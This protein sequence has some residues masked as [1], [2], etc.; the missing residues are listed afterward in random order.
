MNWN[1]KR[2]QREPLDVLYPYYAGFAADFA[3]Q[4]I[5]GAQ[6]ATGARLLDP[7]NG[8]GTTTLAATRLGRSATG[9]DLNPVAALVASAKLAN[10][11]DALHLHGLATDICR[12][13]ARSQA[14]PPPGLTVWLLPDVAAHFSTIQSLVMELLSTP[15]DDA[16]H[17]GNRAPPPIAAFLTA[18]LLRS[19][20]SLAR[21]RTSTNPVWI[22][23]G[24][25]TQYGTGDLNYR[26]LNNITSFSKELGIAARDTPPAELLIGDS[27]S[28]PCED[29][30]F[31]FAITSPPYC[32]RLDYVANT[33]FELAA[34]GLSNGDEQLGELRKAS[35]GTPLTRERRL[36]PIK[37][38]WPRPV[39]QLLQ[40]VQCHPSADSAS[41]YYKNH[42]QYFDDAYESLTEL[43][44][45]LKPGGAAVLVLQT[46][47]YKDVLIDLPELYRA[48][49]RSLGFRSARLASLPVVRVMSQIN[50]RARRHLN[51]RT[52]EEVVIAL[53]TA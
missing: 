13:A 21:V 48:M 30:S 36:Q 49:G 51:D 25:S 32:T 44:R 10:R 5:A 3:T 15:S 14:D 7:W 19:A 38:A 46:S 27:R 28:L 35:M 40:Q 1:T 17:L 8:A 2:T 11:E 52:Y 23:P 12:R 37:P 26:W 33:K 41:Y 50:P 39:H 9:I 6:L 29:D 47:Y 4:V 53:E 20:R 34:L 45:V 16:R 22:R 18:C 24:P 31:D 42:W 43:A